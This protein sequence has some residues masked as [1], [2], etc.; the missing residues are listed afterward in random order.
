[1][2]AMNNVLNQVLTS[3]RVYMT[4][5]ALRTPEASVEQINGPGLPFPGTLAPAQFN[6]SWSQ[7]SAL[8]PVHGIPELTSPLSD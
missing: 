1:M 6:E 4:W 7:F 8:T 3:S 5:L 2:N